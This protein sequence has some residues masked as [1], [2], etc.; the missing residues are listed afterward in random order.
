[1]STFLDFL[2]ESNF[3]P[4]QYEELLL[5][6][7][8]D[9]KNFEWCTLEPESFDAFKNGEEYDTDLE[10]DY[11]EGDFFTCAKYAKQAADSD[12]VYVNAF[13]SVQGAMLANDIILR[14]DPKKK[15]WFI[16]DFR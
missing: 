1:M 9:K 5:A 6:I 15:K 4:K 14:Y 11:G 2:N 13:V 10:R 8:N 3:R 7:A 16:E 12:D